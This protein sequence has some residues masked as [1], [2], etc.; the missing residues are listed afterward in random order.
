MTAADA[1]GAVKA[2]FSGTINVDLG[3]TTLNHTFGANANTPG[4]AYRIDVD[5]EQALISLEDIAGLPE[6][7]YD[8]NDRVWM[9]VVLQTGPETVVHTSISEWTDGNWTGNVTVT[10]T[11]DKLGFEGLY[12][13]NYSF[14][15]FS[16]NPNPYDP[17]MG[18][19]IIRALE[20]S[21]IDNLSGPTNW[22]AEVGVLQ[23]DPQLVCWTADVQYGPRILPGQSANF[24]FTTPVCL[25]AASG[26]EAFDQD[27]AL[28]IGGN[29][30]AP[31]I[32]IRRVM[33]WH[34]GWDDENPNP[35]GGGRFFAEKVK[36]DSPDVS[37]T[38]SVMVMLS[39]EVE[40]DTN[41]N[42]YLYDVD[43]PY[44]NTNPVDDETDPTDNRGDDT[45]LGAFTITVKKDWNLGRTTRRLS[46]QP[47]DNFRAVAHLGTEDLEQYV[48]PKQND[49]RNAGV[50]FF[51]GSAVPERDFH[52]VTSELLTV[53]W[54]LHVERDYMEAFVGDAAAKDAEFPQNEDDP[55]LEN[56]LPKLPLGYLFWYLRDPYIYV[57]NDLE[58][59]NTEQRIGFIHNIEFVV[60][61][62]SNMI[63]VG[64][65]IRNV[66]S[67]DTFWVAQL[68]SAYE[69]P[70]HRD[71]D[72][73]EEGWI[74][75][76][77]PGP[78]MNVTGPCFVFTE[79]IR[80]FEM[81]TI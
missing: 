15:N 18:M 10:V 13:W 76:T 71:R 45:V 25:I 78:S 54:S 66:Q 53:W 74:A 17:G 47:G 62:F 40:Q 57:R 75:G 73:D 29:T 4:N 38:V 52:T 39:H 36:P 34:R 30:M 22:T 19:F 23:G 8:Y 3:G 77:T 67:E 68:F 48:F 5:G 27:Y 55:P 1:T 12:H 65:S 31:D 32:M 2:A 37:D 14:D 41:I 7:D 26:G 58:L 80:E 6:C 61:I 35:G 72:P 81:L 28:G 49:I 51:D 21:R 63:Q 46:R 60:P 16:L 56:A 42:M 44:A 24:S 11:A 64:N 9:M 79:V 69:G 70:K 59:Y 33:W 20:P 43:D 50:Y